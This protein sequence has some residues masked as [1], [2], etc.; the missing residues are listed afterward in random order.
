MRQAV[1]LVIGNPLG[2]LLAISRGIWRPFNMNFPG[3]KVEPGETLEQALVREVFEETDIIVRDPVPIF[4]RECRGE[5]DFECTAFTARW[6]ARKPKVVGRE[7]WVRWVYPHEICRGTFAEYNRKLLE[8]VPG[9]KIRGFGLKMPAS[10]HADEKVYQQWWY[11]PTKSKLD[12]R[13]N[14]LEVDEC[15]CMP[16]RPHKDSDA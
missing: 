15:I 7:G 13:F 4:K 9:H 2:Q 12:L 10:A 5:T 3:G 11:N 8:S 14:P 6:V 1:T 16:V